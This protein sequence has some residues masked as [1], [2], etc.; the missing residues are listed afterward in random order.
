MTAARCMYHKYVPAQ[1]SE[2]MQTGTRTFDEQVQLL[3]VRN[4]AVLHIVHCEI[5][6]TDL[7]FLTIKGPMQTRESPSVQEDTL[8]FT[9]Q[10]VLPGEF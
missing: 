9:K 3:V 2:S 8:W 4:S 1:G 6:H 5:T 7:F 10:R